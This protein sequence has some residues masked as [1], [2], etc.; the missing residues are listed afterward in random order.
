MPSETGKVDNE[1]D[2]RVVKELE[3]VTDKAEV[4]TIRV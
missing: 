1:D 3:E 2:Q 4:G